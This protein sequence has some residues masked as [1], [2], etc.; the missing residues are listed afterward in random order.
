M[1]LVNNGKSSVCILMPSVSRSYVPICHPYVTCM[2]L[3][4]I[5]MSLVFPC[6]LSYVTR[7]YSMSSVRPSNILVFKWFYHEPLIGSVTIMVLYVLE[8][9]TSFFSHSLSLTLIETI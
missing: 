5:G 2:Y 7:M 8:V 6:M 1:S 4:V 9:K 3:D